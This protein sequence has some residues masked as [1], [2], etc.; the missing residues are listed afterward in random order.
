MHTVTIKPQGTRLKVECRIYPTKKDMH[1]AAHKFSG[2]I[3]SNIGRKTE[4]YCEC[5]P[6][7]LPRGFFAVVFFYEKGMTNGILAHEMDHAAQG[8]LYR[9]GHRQLPISIDTAT[10]LEE[11]H[12][13]ILQDLVDDF[14]R[15]CS[16]PM[17]A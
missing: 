14:M 1:A 10:P 13:Y 5:T 17:Y 6:S 12:C 15:K 9:R 2:S 16:L 3:Y 11:E 4:A 7:L 8:L